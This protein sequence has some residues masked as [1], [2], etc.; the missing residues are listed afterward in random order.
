MQPARSRPRCSSTCVYDWHAAPTA[1]FLFFYI[2]F[3]ILTPSLSFTCSFFSHSIVVFLPFMLVRHV[4]FHARI[5]IISPSQNLFCTS[6]CPSI[7]SLCSLYLLSPLRAKLPDIDQHRS[8]AHSEIGAKWLRNPT[9][10]TD[11]VCMCVCV[12]V[13]HVFSSESADKWLE[14]PTECLDSVV[15]VAVPT[16][17]SASLRDNDSRL[18]APSLRAL[19]DPPLICHQTHTHVHTHT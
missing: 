4:D 1:L 13:V 19:W 14:N 10:S 16:S 8:Q 18:S 12:C 11:S 17:G 3:P 2:S 5:F 15:H 9:R 7:F 6:H